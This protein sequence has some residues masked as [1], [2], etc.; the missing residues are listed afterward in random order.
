MPASQANKAASLQRAFKPVKDVAD[1]AGEIWVDAEVRLD[2]ELSKIERAKGG[3]PKTG[4]IT[5]PVSDAPTLAELGVSKKRAAAATKLAAIPPETRKDI[6]QTLKDEGKGVTP[7]AVRVKLG[8][9]S[10]RRSSR[11]TTGRGQTFRP[12]PM[13]HSYAASLKL[14]GAAKF[15]LSVIT[16]KLRAYRRWPKPMRYSIAT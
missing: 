10:A 14:R 4:P 2:E 16:G 12:A 8:T 1:K 11:V 7:A 15:Y 13:P 3:R 9:A 5:E 6:V